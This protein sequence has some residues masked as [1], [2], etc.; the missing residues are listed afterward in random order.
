MV[1][2]VANVGQK[3]FLADSMGASSHLRV[4]RARWK[5]S[6][7]FWAAGMARS[8]TP[9]LWRPFAGS[10][11]TISQKSKRLH[12][13]ALWRLTLVPRP[14]PTTRRSAFSSSCQGWTCAI[15][16]RPASSGARALLTAR[17]WRRRRGLV[18]SWRILDD[19]SGWRT[20]RALQRH[21]RRA[22]WRS[23]VTSTLMAMASCSGRSSR[24]PCR[25]C[26]RSTPCRSQSLWLRSALRRSASASW[27]TPSTFRGMAWL[28]IWSSCMLSSRSTVPQGT[29][30]RR[31]SWS[32]YARRSGRTS[33]A[34]C[35]R[36]RCWKNRAWP[37]ACTSQAESPARVYGK[38]CDH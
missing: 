3:S 5:S 31:T 16:T 29:G 14:P 27:S 4:M 22:C 23:S 13:C 17:T 8:A 7:D 35:G 30:S 37:T 33:P 6:K 32:K 18:Q 26:W 2:L 11:G 21:A 1:R 24:K 10:S 9:M 12:C 36:C 20:W 28:T 34:C 15:G 38:R 19:F 25:H